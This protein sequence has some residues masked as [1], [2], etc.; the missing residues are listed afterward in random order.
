VD[1]NFTTTQRLSLIIESHN[2]TLSFTLDMLAQHQTLIGQLQDEVD[3]LRRQGEA[4]KAR[5]DARDALQ[6]LQY[7][8][9][10]RKSAVD[11]DPVKTSQT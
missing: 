2:S 6:A 4:M 7:R 3:F 5:L 11:Q 10:M 8:V 9:R 1:D